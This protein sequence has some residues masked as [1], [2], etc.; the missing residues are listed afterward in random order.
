[1]E[2]GRQRAVDVATQ[3]FRAHGITAPDAVQTAEVLV[4]ADARGKHSHGL[5]RLPRF[6]RGIEHGNVD[7]DGTIA[8]ASERG[9]A[10]TISGGSRLGP[11]VASTAT[12]EAMD[13]A[14]NH[15]VGAVGVRDSNHLGM[16]GYYT[17]QL[18]QAG[19]VG[20]AMT[21]T[22]PA[23]PPYG[24]AE[25]VLGT[26]P[27]AIGLP[28]DPVFN[29]D[30][31][32]SAIA[33][34][35]VFQEQETG[36]E[37]PE[38]VALDADGQPTTDPAAALDGTMLPFGG[39]KGSGLAVAVEVLAGGLV[40]AS[41]GEAVTGTYHTEDPCTKG[42]LFLAID[43]DALGVSDF[44]DRASSFLTTLTNGAPAAH[45]DEIRLPGQR[46]VERDRNAT[47]VTVADDLWAEA[48]A[49][50]TDD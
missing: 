31:S 4:S 44:A 3:A 32:T 20:I 41:M 46:S 26:N 37:L 47:T 2:I 8:V 14:E 12:A 23:M 5:L 24:G 28:T 13:R 38:G 19:Y 25:P 27:I 9:G 30:M 17:D 21:N 45:A 16:L 7:P 43:P 1:M 11:A 35:T 18:Q 15:G 49:L 40:G 50:A 36:G 42:D 6:V 48:Q 39:P 10:A 33:R 34:G 22:E 29:L